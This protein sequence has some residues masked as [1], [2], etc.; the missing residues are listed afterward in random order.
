MEKRV[1]RRPLTEVQKFEANEYVAA[2]GDSGTVYLFE[3]NAGDGE[4]ADIYLNNGQNLTEGRSRYFHA[5]EKKH[6]APSTD[7]FQSG[8]MLL[9]GGNDETGHWVI[10]GFLDWDYVE[11]EKIPVIIWTGD[12]DV[13]ATTNLDQHSWETLKS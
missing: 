12:G 2:C 1:W 8:Y 11:Y 4:H 10:N 9:N 5:C 13:H 6:P 7:D 3:C